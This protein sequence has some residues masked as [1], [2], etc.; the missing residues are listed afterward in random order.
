[1][2]QAE[3]VL[4]EEQVEDLNDTSKAVFRRFPGFLTDLDRLLKDS[5]A[6]PRLEELECIKLLALL[7]TACLC[8]AGSSSPPEHL[9]P[10]V[11]L[12]RPLI[13]GSLGREKPKEGELHSQTSALVSVEGLSLLELLLEAIGMIAQSSGTED[14]L[15]TLLDCVSGAVEAFARS[16]FLDARAMANLRQELLFVAYSPVLVQKSCPPK[17]REAMMH[18]LRPFRP[19]PER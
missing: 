13:V 16:S 1:V 17:L 19:D 15:L 7:S 9:L 8:W 5:E 6:R 18:C 2:N 14:V 3:I 12:L 4:T 10:I 11:S